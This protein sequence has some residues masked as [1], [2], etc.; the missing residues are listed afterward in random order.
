MTTN[1]L[2]PNNLRDHRQKAGL[3]QADVAKA[4]GFASTDRISHWEK[5]RAVPHLVNLFKLAALYQV[6]PHELYP[7]LLLG[8]SSAGERRIEE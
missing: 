3:L 4:L 7:S 2:I 1:N 5:G 6:F 8:N